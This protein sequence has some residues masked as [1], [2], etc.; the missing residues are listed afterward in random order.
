M[1]G[2]IISVNL[3]N[4][5]S[6]IIVMLFFFSSRRRHTRWPRDWSSDVCSSDL[7]D[8]A[9]CTPARRA[10]GGGT[11]G[12]GPLAAAGIHGHAG[13]AGRIFLFF[14]A[15]IGT[16]SGNARL[17]PEAGGSGLPGPPLL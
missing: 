4:I 11:S 9:E 7:G 2:R 12:L 10:R 17:A 14:L 16:D 8:L 3:Y 6:C 1:L 13:G 5:C 15:P